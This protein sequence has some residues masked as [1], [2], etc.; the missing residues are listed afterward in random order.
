MEIIDFIKSNPMIIIIAFLV[1]VIIVQKIKL[2]VKISKE[3]GRMK[4]EYDKLKSE[5]ESSSYNRDITFSK[6][7]E[8]NNL[9]IE[10]LK[11]QIDELNKANQNLTTNFNNLKGQKYKEIETQILISSIEKI[12]QDPRISPFF[13]TMWDNAKKEATKEIEDV[14]IGRRILNFL[15]IK[16]IKPLNV[17][18]R[19]NDGKELTDSMIGKIESKQ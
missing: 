2:S 15:S 8:Q 9:E 6:M 3:S 14:S 19:I 12:Q 17:N 13:A 16:N 10:S 18:D 4:S 7:V 5:Y 11:K 1:I